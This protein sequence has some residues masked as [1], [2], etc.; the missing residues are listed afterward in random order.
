LDQLF[1]VSDAQLHDM[2]HNQDE[3]REL[4]TGFKGF[5]LEELKMPADWSTRKCRYEAGGVARLLL[6]R[7]EAHSLL[8]SCLFSEHIR[9][10]IHPSCNTHKFS[11]DMVGRTDWGTPWHNCAYKHADGSWS[12][13]R[14][15]QAETNGLELVTSKHTLA[16]YVDKE[17]NEKPDMGA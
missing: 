2:I 14:R 10:S 3:Y 12:L 8:V 4:F 16:H 9:L 7:N 17:R 6:R 11:I 13:I 15:H 1:G 5:M